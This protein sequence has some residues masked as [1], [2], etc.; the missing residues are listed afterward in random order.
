MSGAYSLKDVTNWSSSSTKTFGHAFT[1]HGKAEFNYL[2]ERLKN[3]KQFPEQG[4]WLDNVRAAAVLESVKEEIDEIELGEAQ[5]F[6]MPTNIGEILTLDETGKVIRT[7]V[8]R[9]RVV[10]GT[11]K[12]RSFIKTAFPI[13]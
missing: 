1:Y 10:R 12:S 3:D 5:D 7:P 6:N 9:F 13:L 2:V 11:I 4:H 8:T